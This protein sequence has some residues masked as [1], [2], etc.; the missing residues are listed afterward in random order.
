MWSC[1]FASIDPYNIF[2][3]SR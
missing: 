2:I 1:T 3:E